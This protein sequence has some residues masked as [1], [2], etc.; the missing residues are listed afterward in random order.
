[1]KTLGAWIAGI[2]AL[3]LALG[4]F[5][6]GSGARPEPAASALALTP[7]LHQVDC[8]EGREALL[9]PFDVDGTTS[10]KVRC[11][12]TEVKRPT[13]VVSHP[14]PRAP[15]PVVAVAPPHPEPEVH[16]AEPA[17]DEIE[18]DDADDPRSWKQS[19]VVIGGAAGPVL[20]PGLAPSPRAR[21]VQRS[22]PPSGPR[23]VRL[24]RCSRGTRRSRG[25]GKARALSPRLAFH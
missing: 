16:V 22:V 24:T 6:S 10:F 20:G 5:V 4:S 12:N 17:V 15:A 3:G 8:G 14:A 9:E 25:F 13:R 19:A 11:V 21:R 18:V 7:P 1:M 23:A 2:F